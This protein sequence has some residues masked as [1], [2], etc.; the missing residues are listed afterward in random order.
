M[1]AHCSHTTEAP[2]TVEAS[3]GDSPNSVVPGLSDR[4]SLR[5]RQ[6]DAQTTESCDKYAATQPRGSLYDN[7]CRRN[8]KTGLYGH[9]ASYLYSTDATQYITHVLPLMLLK[10]WR[11]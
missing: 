6:L 9:Q 2:V 10:S 7:T 3:R 5:V 11:C 8:L 1:D 4:G